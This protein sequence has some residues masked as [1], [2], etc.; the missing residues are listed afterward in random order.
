MASNHNYPIPHDTITIQSTKKGVNP[1]ELTPSTLLKQPVALSYPSQKVREAWL[2]GTRFGVETT[3]MVLGAGI[4]VF[5]ALAAML[6]PKHDKVVL[7]HAHL[8]KTHIQKSS[9]VAS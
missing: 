1:F 6:W 9:Q 3:A 7:M 5:A 8:E 4:L 2:I